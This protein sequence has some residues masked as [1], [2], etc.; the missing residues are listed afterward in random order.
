MRIAKPFPGGRL[1]SRFAASFLILLLP[2]L[3]RPLSAQDA[4]GSIG[5]RV[6]DAQ[7]ALIAGARVTATNQETGVTVSAVTNEVG[8]FRLPFLLPGKYRVTVETAGFRKYEQTDVELRVTDR[9]D[10]PI[11]MEVGGVAEVIEVKG[12]TPLLE[13]SNSSLGQVMDTKRLD[14]LP[15]RGGNPLELER[16]AP[17]VANMTTLRT[18]RSSSPASASS[19][20]VN[21][22][23][24]NKTQFNIDGVNNTTNDQGRGFARVAFSPPPS[25]VNEFK[26]QSNPYDATVG[27]VFGAV[28]NISSKGGS[29]ELHGNLY[30]FAKNSAFDAM[31]FFDNKA[32][33]PKVVY[34]DHR[35]GLTAGGP[36]VIPHVYNGH[37]KTFFFYS[38]DQSRFTQPATTNQTSTVPTAAEREGDFSALLKLGSAYQ[39]Y[40][41]FTTRP[42]AAA[43]RYQRNPFPGNL[44]PKS[45]LSPVGQN[46]A[47]LYPLPSQQALADGRNNYYYT[48]VRPQRYDSHMAR[49]DQAFS[50]NHR[51]FVRLNH[52]GY[53]NTKDL[54]GIPATR[55]YFNQFNQGIALDDV[56][57]LSPAWV[58]NVRYGVVNARFPE[59]RATQG[60]DL[61]KLGF[62]PTLVNLIDR[63]LAAVP[64]LNLGGFSKLSNWSDGDGAATA[65][66]HTWMGDLSTLRGAHSIRFGIDFRLFRGFSDRYA[67]GISPDFI[68]PTNYT[69]GP[70]DNAAAASIGQEL[71][72]MLLGVPGGSMS[73]TAS[74]AGQNTYF[75]LYFQDDYKLSRKLTVNL[76]L[77]YEKEYPVTDRYDRLV[78]GFDSASASPVEAAARTAYAKNPIGELPAAQFSAKGGLTFVG[79]DHRSPFHGNR[80][81]LL[82]RIG[83]AYQATSSTVVRAGYGVYFDSLGV[84]TYLPLQ[85]GFTQT[86]PIQASLDNGQTYIANVANPV[87]NGLLPPL[88]AQGGLATN[89]GQGIRYTDPGMKQAYSQRW[90]LGVQ[91]FLP[92]QFLI[93][94][95]YV[96]TRGTHL[97]VTR[98]INSTPAQYLSTA[99]LRD[100]AT[101]D[102]L[103]Q[104][105]PNPFKGLNPVYGSRISRANLL[106]PYPQFGD[107]SVIQPDGYSWYHSLQLRAEKRFSKGYT[108]QVGYTFSKYMQATEFLNPSDPAPYRSLSDLDRPH[109]LTLSGVWELPFGRGRRFGAAMPGPVSFV[110]SGWQLNGTVIR[111][112]GGA[113]DFG[114]VI[115]NGDIHN[116]PLPK[117]ERAVERWFNTNAGFERNSKKQLANNIRTF[118]LRLAGLRGDGQATWNFALS[119]NFRIFERLQAQFRAEAYN[120]MNHPSFADPKMGVTG[121]SFGVVSKA[122]SE[123]RSWQFALKFKF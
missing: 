62:S 5:G 25:A 114:N 65:L 81:H 40:N 74:Y 119:K 97:A 92:G 123:P 49:I 31:N 63:R 38:W 99:P 72:A 75:G 43:G 84:D 9:L 70:L 87:P 98:D 108:L 48:D 96:G 11:H 104:T 80:G 16:L 121:S 77:R 56:L 12:G 42:A 46:L 32:G 110:V 78:A 4:R 83:L 57:V 14:D 30:Y 20:T 8:S 58:L 17:G 112:A 79:A 107:I 117:G 94:A 93:D 22:T 10:L 54:M 34:H 66:T 82:P 71:A 55:E 64:R 122:D 18:Q 105:F 89:L 26:L 45:L 111:Q 29:N 86:T 73:R 109:L 27:H 102:Y 15:V 101:I 103:T 3:V 116:I 51:L 6:M 76:G 68:F 28:V 47:A 67:P 35:Y 7:D 118:P 24:V 88:G 100:Q 91:Q 69:R 23:G 59:R 115:F 13:T 120:A 36:V 106:R 113:L 1:L 50:E 2:T 53:T 95:S 90:S 52:Y 19:I 21:G 44:I 33:L 41:P 60:T 39:I 37:N 85:T 61:S